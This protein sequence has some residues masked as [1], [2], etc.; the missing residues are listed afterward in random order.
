M[1]AY[2]A[3]TTLVSKKE[4]PFPAWLKAIVFDWVKTVEEET[5]ALTEVACKHV[6]VWVAVGSAAALLAVTSASASAHYDDHA[7]CGGMASCP[8]YASRLQ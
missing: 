7:E 5:E 8:A 4:I 6:A 1:G 2:I 3:D